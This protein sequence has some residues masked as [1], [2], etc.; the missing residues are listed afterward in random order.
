MNKCPHCGEEVNAEKPKCDKCGK[1]MSASVIATELQA[2]L[3]ALKAA[4]QK[5]TDLEAS[6]ADVTQ[7]NADI[8][9]EKDKVIAEKETALSD[10]DGK[11]SALSAQ[12]RRTLLGSFMTDEEFEKDKATITAMADDAFNLMVAS[13]SKKQPEGTAHGFRLIEK[14]TPASGNEKKAIRLS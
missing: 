1:S 2:A 14:Q 7:K 9:A 12:L 10:K 13:L 11:F 6:L 3:D 5:V 4:T 8:V